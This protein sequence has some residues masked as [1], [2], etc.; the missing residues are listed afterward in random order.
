V[1]PIDLFTTASTF[2]VFLTLVEV[3]GV[4]MLSGR[5]RPATAEHVDRIAR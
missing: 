5:D 2:L 4:I 1:T 3:T